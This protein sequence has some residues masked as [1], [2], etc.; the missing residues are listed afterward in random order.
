[1]PDDVLT[2]ERCYI[3]ELLNHCSSP[4]VS[5]ARA[6]VTPGVTTQLH[7]LSVAEWYVIESGEGTVRVGDTAPRHVARGD[8][9]TIPAGV[10]QQITNDGT[11]D[12][13][14]LCVCVPR[15]TATCYTNLEP[16]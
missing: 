13:C 10:A 14:F 11:E 3:A 5:L 9:V 16:S 2:D 12:L 7:A 4:E 15:F 8:V 1:M 6:R